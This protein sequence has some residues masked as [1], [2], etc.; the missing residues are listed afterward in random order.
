MKEVGLLRSMKRHG[1]VGS[2][3]GIWFSLL[4]CGAYVA[5][6]TYIDAS[7]RGVNKVDLY[8]FLRRSCEESPMIV[9]VENNHDSFGGK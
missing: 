1:N 8:A 5:P 7:N 9:S 2:V 6:L 4:S 3:I